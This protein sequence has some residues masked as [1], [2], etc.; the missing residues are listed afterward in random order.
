ML[1]LIFGGIFTDAISG[2]VAVV[3]GFTGIFG[4][5][6]HYGATLAG[7]TKPEVER[8]TAF[9]FFIGVAFGAFVLM[10]DVVT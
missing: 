1:G 7:R 4:G 5:A 10:V 8:A 2:A 3:L 9:G 6:A